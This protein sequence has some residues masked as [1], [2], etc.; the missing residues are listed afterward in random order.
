[1]SETILEPIFTT[2]PRL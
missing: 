2:A 1:M